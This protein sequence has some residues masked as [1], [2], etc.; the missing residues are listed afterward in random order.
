MKSIIVLATAAALLGGCAVGPGYGDRR[1]GY[2]DGYYSERGYYRDDRD[3]RDYNYRDDRRYQ[4]N[5]FREHAE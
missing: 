4:T 5:P 3:G 1:D 2:R